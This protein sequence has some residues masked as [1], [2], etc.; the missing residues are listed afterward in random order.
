MGRVRLYGCSA[1]TE[2]RAVAARS[3]GF[4]ACSVVVV[5][6]GRLVVVGR[7]TAI[8][9]CDGYR[10]IVMICGVVSLLPLPGE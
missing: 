6:A 1:S 4:C 8:G 5:T 3:V 9:V 10:Y 7:F 2:R